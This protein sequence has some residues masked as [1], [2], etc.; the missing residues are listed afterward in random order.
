V[1]A[2]V[3]SPDGTRVATGSGD[4]GAGGSARVY[5][6]ATGTELARLDH[7]GPVFAVVFSPDGTRV[8]T[9][10]GGIRGG[11]AQVFE[12]TP[13]LLVQHAINVM[14]RTLNAAELRRYSLSP[15]C[16]HIKR[17]LLREKS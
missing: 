5:Q 15:N 13:D 14:T 10:S 17:W 16:R 3:F 1:F 2:L 6:A 8:A 4:I 9:A 12:A 7:D 11:S